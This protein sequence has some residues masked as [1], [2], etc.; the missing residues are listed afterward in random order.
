MQK[1][2][3]W[4]HGHGGTN[5]NRSPS[6]SEYGTWAAMKARC[7]NPNNKRW[8]RYGG[9]GI[10]VCDHWIDFRNFLA[11]MG[12]RPSM[13]HSLE[14]IDNDG[15]YEPSNCCWA[16]PKDQGSNTV[17]NRWLEWNGRRLTVY[18]AVRETG[19]TRGCI[20]K[21]LSMGWPIEDALTRPVRGAA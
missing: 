19:F 17:R 7:S 21:R 9:R 13:K 11:D 14:R 1:L 2:H 10:K 3:S 8:H 12:L 20:E 15:N 4:K 18:Q 16:M 6:S 5:R